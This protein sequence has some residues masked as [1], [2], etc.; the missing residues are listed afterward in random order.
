MSRAVKRRPE[1][2]DLLTKPRDEARAELLRVVSPCLASG[3]ATKNWHLLQSISPLVLPDGLPGPHGWLGAAS[4]GIAGFM[5]SLLT[6]RA[7]QLGTSAL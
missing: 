6:R 2:H 4:Q 7:K 1:S 5:G 3:S